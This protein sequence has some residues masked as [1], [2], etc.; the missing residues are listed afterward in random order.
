MVALVLP[1]TDGFNETSITKNLEVMGKQGGFHLQGLVQL[2]Y[3]F[4]TVDQLCDD[5]PAGRVSYC[6]EPAGT[7]IF[8]VDSVEDHKTSSEANN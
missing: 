3:I 4:G 1:L 5:S 8:W 7:K 6:L 2:T